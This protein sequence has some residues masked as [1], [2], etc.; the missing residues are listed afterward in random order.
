M[1]RNGPG[2]ADLNDACF[3]EFLCDFHFS[4]CDVIPTSCIQLRNLILSAR[5]VGGTRPSRRTVWPL[6]GTAATGPRERGEPCGCA[7]GCVPQR[8]ATRNRKRRR[9][10]AACDTKPSGRPHAALPAGLPAKHMRLPDP[11]NPNLK[12]DLLPEISQPPRILSDFHEGPRLR[13]AAARARHVPQQ[14][15][16]EQLPPH[17]AQQA[18]AP[19]GGGRAGGEYNVLVMNALVLY[20]GT[21]ALQDAIVQLKAG[22]TAPIV[23]LAPMDV[24]Q[25]LAREGGTRVPLLHIA[26]LEVHK[27]HT[28][29]QHEPR[30]RH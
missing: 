21:H 12:V 23:H 2:Q 24:F 27:M 6:L 17:P 5:G 9:D 26:V 22:I 11:F 28:G 14:A 15:R 13:R 8:R 18:H 16:A 20:V 10:Q 25:Q 1:P 3:P 4:F 7:A 30:G 29:L 19:R